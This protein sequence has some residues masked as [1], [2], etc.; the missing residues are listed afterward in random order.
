MPLPPPAPR[1]PKCDGTQ[2][3]SDPIVLCVP[4]EDAMSQFLPEA[5]EAPEEATTSIFQIVPA[6][7]LSDLPSAASRLAATRSRRT[8]T[9]RVLLLV[10]MTANVLRG[11]IG[12]TTRVMYAA[13]YKGWHCAR[14]LTQITARNVRSRLSGVSGSAITAATIKSVHHLRAVARVF[15]DGVADR[16]AALSHSV[17]IRPDWRVRFSPMHALMLSSRLPS[18][19]VGI[20]VGAVVMWSFA[21]RPQTEVVTAQKTLPSADTTAPV[22]D[23]RVTTQALDASPKDLPR[24]PPLRAISAVAA[25]TTAVADGSSSP[26]RRRAVTRPTAAARPPAVSTR[27]GVSSSAVRYRGTLAIDSVAKGARVFI[28]GKAVGVTPLVL[29]NLP[30]GSRAV[31][32]EAAGYRPWSASLQVTANQQTRVMAKLDRADLPN[33]IVSDA[34]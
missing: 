28:N 6:M 29:K 23:V 17:K 30:S 22:A 13:A 32:V 33:E 16:C 31:R 3:K 10:A 2:P 19:S 11:S 34:R 25:K 15:C 1:R 9:G 12:R 27:R 26:E 5:P 14:V 8:R 4:I 18:F 21:L 24:E 7:L 20:A